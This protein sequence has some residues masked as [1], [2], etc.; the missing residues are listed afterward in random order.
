M[1]E[2]ELGFMKELKKIYAKI[3]KLKINYFYTTQLFFPKYI[4]PELI[5]NDTN[6]KA[7]K[8]N[9]GFQASPHQITSL[10]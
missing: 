5:R 10:H 7:V 2:V 3:N 9:S 6:V 8:N 4:F 1:I